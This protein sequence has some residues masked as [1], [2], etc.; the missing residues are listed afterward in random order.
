VIE[1]RFA[2]A[3]DVAALLE[4]WAVAAENDARP[5]DTAGAVGR[6]T[7]RD[8]EAVIVAVEAGAIVGSVI[9][10]WDG[11]RYHLYRLAVHPNSR[12]RG[13]GSELVARA[14]ARFVA[15]GAERVDAMVLEGNELGQ[16]VWR[17]EGYAPQSEWRRWVKKPE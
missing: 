9:A 11:W 12:R 5:V 13:I 7:E 8:P 14:E 15:L 6:L 4:L 3:V 2:T 1:Y 16:Q 17:R 10:G